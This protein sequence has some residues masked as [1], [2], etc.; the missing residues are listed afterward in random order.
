[1]NKLLIVKKY[2]FNLFLFLLIIGFSE[3]CRTKSSDSYNPYSIAEESNE[4]TNE[5]INFIH[6]KQIMEGTAMLPELI[7]ISLKAAIQTLLLQDSLQGN[8]A[9]TRFGCPDISYVQNA[10][11]GGGTMTLLFDDGNGDCETPGVGSLPKEYAG[12]V[13]I[14]FDN[15]PN[16]G[17]NTFR[18][19]PL[20]DFRIENYTITTTEDW[21]FTWLPF[22]DFFVGG[23][24][25]PLT[26]TDTSN[27]NTTIYEANP[28]DPGDELISAWFAGPNTINP[29]VMATRTYRFYTADL[30]DG[31]CPGQE[32]P[33]FLKVTCTSST[34]GLTTEYKLKA[35]DL[36]T[37]IS[38]TGLNGNGNPI[39]CNGNVFNDVDP[40]HID[41][42]NCGCYRNGSMWIGPL[43]GRTAVVEYNWGY[44]QDSI[45]RPNACDE[46]VLKRQGGVT[47]DLFESPICTQ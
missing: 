2:P 34:T 33:D 41:P 19:S 39:N 9:F 30:T 20:S 37:N 35:G 17:G 32:S 23:F 12:T 6:A 40:M 14:I 5:E 22:D 16:L 21:V 29:L 28:D 25:A 8:S 3:S 46:Y 38:G 31:I 1:M 13:E 44:D 26:V 15:A 24:Q 47:P 45:S 18:I 43:D 42:L 4:L 11:T 10:V 27:N 7:N 36:D